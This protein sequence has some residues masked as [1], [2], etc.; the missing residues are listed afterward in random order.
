MD[1][2]A[3]EFSIHSPFYESQLSKNMKINV[4]KNGAWGTYRNLPLPEFSIRSPSAYLDASV[5]GDL[6]TLGF[7]TGSAD[8]ER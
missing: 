1:E 6:S 3:P 2:N 8:P 4:Y 7:V 5:Y